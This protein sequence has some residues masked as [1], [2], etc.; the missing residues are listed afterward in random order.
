MT[1]APL[2]VGL[3]PGTPSVARDTGAVVLAADRGAVVLAEDRGAGVFAGDRGAAIV[4]FIYLGLLLLLPLVYIIVAASTVQR[5]SYGVTAATREAG[6]AFVTA[7]DGVDPYAEAAAAATLAMR[8]Q[9]LTLPAGGLR[10][11]CAAGC[12]TPG[13]RVDIALDYPVALPL[14]PS[15]LGGRPLASITVHGRHGEVF[16]RFRAQQ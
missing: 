16:D 13:S 2:P 9:G 15:A 7:G 4:E 10:I 5:A 3:R 12:G 8:D 14:V 1:A 11:S 6:R